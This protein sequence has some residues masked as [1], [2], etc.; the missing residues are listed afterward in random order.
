MTSRH[1]GIGDVAFFQ[2]LNT[3]DRDLR[4]AFTKSVRG[5]VVEAYTRGFRAGFDAAKPPIQANDPTYDLIQHASLDDVAAFIEARDAVREIPS[6]APA[7]DSFADT[8]PLP[9]STTAP[10]RAP[11][12]ERVPACVE[13]RHGSA[14]RVEVNGEVFCLFC[15][16][17]FNDEAS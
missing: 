12:T 6:S 16:Q 15:S 2:G 8:I 13:P 14:L 11:V 3:L 17:P 5:H 4:D 1:V 9:A 10:P 7:P